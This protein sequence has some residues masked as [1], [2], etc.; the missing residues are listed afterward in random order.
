M[1]NRMIVTV[2]VGVLSAALIDLNAYI[3]ARGKDAKASFDW[4]LFAFRV[5]QGLFL[6]FVGALT[7]ES[8][9]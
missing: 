8:I 2:V 6:G 3:A 1:S 4:T 5:T 9:G 7:G